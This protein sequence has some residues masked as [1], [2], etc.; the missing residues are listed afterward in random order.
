MTFHSKAPVQKRA[1][2][3]VDVVN[4]VNAVAAPIEVTTITNAQYTLNDKHFHSLQ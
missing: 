4:I 1:F 3:A 2:V